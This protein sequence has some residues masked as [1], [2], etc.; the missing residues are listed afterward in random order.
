MSR[1]ILAS[2]TVLSISVPVPGECGDGD[3]LLDLFLVSSVP[4][5][6]SDLRLVSRRDVRVVGIIL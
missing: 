1:Q 3:A 4:S 6:S 5:S 2:Y